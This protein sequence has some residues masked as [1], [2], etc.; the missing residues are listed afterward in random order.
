MWIFDNSS[1][2]ATFLRIAILWPNKYNAPWVPL[3]MEEVHQMLLLAKV[4]PDDLVYDLGCGDG[5]IIITAAREYGTRAVGIELDPLRY[6]WC[7]LLITLFGLRE[8]AQVIYGD[9]FDQDLTEAEVVT[10]Y[11][12]QRTNNRLKEKFKRELRPG[13]RVVSYNFTFSDLSEV[14]KDGDS[15]L[16][17]FYPEEDTAD[18]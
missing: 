15:R 13:T 17:L 18:N 1:L 16:Y 10:C 14:C 11:L 6:I 4:V 9:F 3:S 12:L 5:R 2:Q 8:R 7:Q